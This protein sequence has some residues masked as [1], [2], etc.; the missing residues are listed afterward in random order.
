MWI[1]RQSHRPRTRIFD[2]RLNCRLDQLVAGLSIRPS[3]GRARRSRCRTLRFNAASPRQRRIRAG[4]SQQH[5]GVTDT[6][7]VTD[8]PALPNLLI[9]PRP[10]RGI[11]TVSGD[12]LRTS[13]LPTLAID[14]DDRD[15][16]IVA[17]EYRTDHRSGNLGLQYQSGRTNGPVGF[18]TPHLQLSDP[19]ERHIGHSD[20][21][22]W[23]SCVKGPWSP[24][25]W[26]FG[27]TMPPARPGVPSWRA[28]T[29]FWA[30][31]ICSK[32][33]SLTRYV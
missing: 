30:T 13:Q 3:I 17:S 11:A 27:D 32:E 10:K 25:P 24:G 15:M 31:G 33:R 22:A 19:L 5:F 7:F 16:A 12:A 2:A 4:V 8:D 1:T 18:A 6:R 26:S 9:V 20:A 21:I 28:R 29:S 23:R 14:R